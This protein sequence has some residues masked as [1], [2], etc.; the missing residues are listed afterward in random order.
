MLAGLLARVLLCAAPLALTVAIVDHV[1]SVGSGRR[2]ESSLFDVDR[3]VSLISE[4]IYLA[5]L[6]SVLH[7]G[8][9][10]PVIAPLSAENEARKL[11]IKCTD[12]SIGSLLDQVAEQTGMTW[13][14]DGQFVVFSSLNPPVPVV[15]EYSR[16][17]KV[18]ELISFWDSLSRDQQY[19][20]GKGALSLA[21]LSEDQLGYLAKVA[22]TDPKWFLRSADEGPKSLAAVTLALFPKIVLRSSSEIIERFDARTSNGSDRSW[23]LD[24]TNGELTVLPPEHTWMGEMAK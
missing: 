4:H 7:N 23:A 22:Q 18:K 12:D 2:A 21:S 1:F 24:A 20:L 17:R 16:P 15:R 5:E 14:I 10:I 19:R 6:L 11:V 3:R 9:K 13:R 8:Y